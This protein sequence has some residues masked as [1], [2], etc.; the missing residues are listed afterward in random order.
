MS[1]FDSLGINA[2]ELM[3]EH[4]TD[5]CRLVIGGRV[6]QENSARLE[7]GII[8]T[9]RRYARVEVDL[10]GVQEIDGCGIRLIGLMQRLGG[11]E[12]Q[13]VAASPAFRNAA[14][15]RSG[16]PRVTGQMH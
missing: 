9:M 14:E 11:K 16:S 8:D 5:G 3:L 4:N 12:V 2:M 6:T 15:R 10:A 13:I 1:G 7:A